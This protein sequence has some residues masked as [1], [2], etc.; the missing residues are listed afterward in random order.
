VRFMPQLAKENHSQSERRALKPDFPP[1]SH[2]SYQLDTHA[3][4]P[5]LENIIPIGFIY[6]TLWTLL[7]KLGTDPPV[8]SPGADPQ[9]YT[10]RQFFKFHSTTSTSIVAEQEEGKWHSCPPWP[11][12]ISSSDSKL[13]KFNAIPATS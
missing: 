6:G 11:S 8:A 13:S 2:L 3:S 10:R 5:S 7:P 12:W 1:F 9:I 4:V